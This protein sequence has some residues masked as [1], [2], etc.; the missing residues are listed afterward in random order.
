VDVERQRL[1]NNVESR[2]L[3]GSRVQHCT[4]LD[5]GGSPQV[6]IHKLHAFLAAACHHQC[7]ESVNSR[8]L[9]LYGPVIFRWGKQFFSSVSPPVIFRNLL[10]FAPWLARR[11]D[12]LFSCQPATPGLQDPRFAYRS[13]YPGMYTFVRTYFECICYRPRKSI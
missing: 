12:F 10:P 9:G 6:W 5:V 11:G 2:Q 7:K 1:P 13:L 3:F 4:S 8:P